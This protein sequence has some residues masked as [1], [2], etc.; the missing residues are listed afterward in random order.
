LKR[1]G[2]LLLLLHRLL[3]W[4]LNSHLWRRLMRGG[5]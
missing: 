2:L 5:S 3:L 4:L 1:I